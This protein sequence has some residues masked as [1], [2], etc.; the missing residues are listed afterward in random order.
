MSRGVFGFGDELDEEEGLLGALMLGGLGTAGARATIPVQSGGAVTNSA[1]STT[2]LA[3]AASSAAASRISDKV[4]NV[5][6]KV[7]D[8]T[9]KVVGKVI[10][11]VK[12]ARTST[13]Q[14]AA[15]AAA[16]SALAAAASA[17]TSASGTGISQSVL[18]ASQPMV[19]I[20]P[21]V[22]D[23]DDKGIAIVRTIGRNNL[24]QK[25]G[26]DINA[27][28]AAVNSISSINMAAAG[29]PI[30]SSPMSSIAMISKDGFDDK[31][32]I[33]PLM[34]TG[35][36]A[37]A[38]TV[39]VANTGINALATSSSN[40]AAAAAAINA[41]NAN[42]LNTNN[43]NF[44]GGLNTNSANLLSTSLTNNMGVNTNLGLGGLTQ[45]NNAFLPGIGFGLGKMMDGKFFFKD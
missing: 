18:T 42:S 25:G 26:N 30:V 7:A 19:A 11:N 45:Q 41:N 28:N 21:K 35:T 24:V 20:S 5:A 33:L 9:K 17:A 22:F 44:L 8:A 23:G 43:A 37:V 12:D 16:A 4:G 36:A 2:A 3:N 10:D 39:N 34:S 29:P 14:R 40:A 38:P 32:G 6:E 31:F 1:L 13:V 15:T 27:I